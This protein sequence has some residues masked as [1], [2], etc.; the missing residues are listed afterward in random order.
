MKLFELSVDQSSYRRGDERDPRS[1][2]YDGDDER[3]VAIDELEDPID[4]LANG[5]HK[6]SRWYQDNV[7]DGADY[8]RD[9]KTGNQF[10]RF[11]VGSPEAAKQLVQLINMS[12]DFQVL[13]S[14]VSNG[15]VP[16]YD[17]DVTVASISWGPK[18]EVY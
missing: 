5:K 3:A 2:Y 12:D 17:D 1:P 18:R 6:Y 13:D 15:G 7:Q 4:E 10:M 16:G 14:K 8:K 9:P 11:I